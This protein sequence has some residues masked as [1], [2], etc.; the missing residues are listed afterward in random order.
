MRNREIE[1]DI[2]TGFL[3]AGKTTFIQSTLEDKRFNDGKQQTLLLI[4]EEGEVEYDLSKMPNVKSAVIDRDDL[5]EE[6]LDMLAKTN[7]AEKIVI[8]YN[9]MWLINDFFEAMPEDWA[10][11]Q[12]MFIADAGTFAA[13]NANMRQ[14]VYDKINI[15]SM[16]AFNR[17][18]GDTD[19]MELHKIVRGA[20][21]RCQIVYEYK[22]G[23][24]KQDDIVDP[25][26]FDVNAPVIDVADKDFALF[27]GDVM[28]NP[29]TYNGKT[30]RFKGICARDASLPKG[31]F[32]CG[33]H[34]M[35]CCAADIQYYCWLVEGFAGYE[36]IQHAEWIIL[37]A[38]LNIKFSRA[39]G[40]KGP[41]LKAIKVTKCDPLPNDEAVA[42]FY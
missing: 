9:G 40:K 21:R 41:V 20:N 11:Y 4:C 38:Q 2:F 36:A 31:M 37:E 6:R 22:D 12:F 18:D 16:C 35:T 3:D 10:I 30:V 42:S 29:K 39:Y 19:F 26:P 8:E 28:D 1:V 17:L 23:T 33:R 7:R 5:V 25:M 15:T 27:F 13:Y 32:A 14:F 24:T 34:I